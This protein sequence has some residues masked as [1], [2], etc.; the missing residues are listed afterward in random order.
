M[1]TNGWTDGLSIVIGSPQSQIRNVRTFV[2]LYALNPTI[3]VS[4]LFLFSFFISLFIA[5]LYSSPIYSF[6]YSFLHFFVFIL[7]LFHLFPGRKE[8][9]K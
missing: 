9:N 4:F 8:K 6:I 5:Y 2:N 7:H 3:Y 1:R